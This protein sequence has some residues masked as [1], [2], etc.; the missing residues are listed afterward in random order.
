MN[1][2]DFDAKSG[3]EDEHEH[4]HE[5]EHEVQ[6]ALGEALELDTQSQIFLQLRRQNLDLLR[7][8]SEV[9]GYGSAHAP[10]QEDQLKGAMQNIWEVFS[11][12][13]TWID[14]EEAEDDDE[15]ED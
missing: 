12:F 5:C 1:A 13:Y 10:V 3:H 14:P 8:A 2:N 15:E 9:A 4:D 11:E 6:E 7:L